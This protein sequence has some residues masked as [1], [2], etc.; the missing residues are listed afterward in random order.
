[1]GLRLSALHAPTASPQ[2]APVGHARRVDH[3]ARSAGAVDA[4]DR[5]LDAAC[6]GEA[7]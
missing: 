5:D 2:R 6:P 3:A 4:G 7:S 1:M